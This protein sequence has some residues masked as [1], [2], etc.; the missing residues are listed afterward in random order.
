MGL[1]RALLLCLLLAAPATAAEPG[2]LRVGVQAPFVLDP[3][4]LFLGPN[5]AAARHIFDSLVGRDADSRWVPSLA[6][7]W[8]ALDETTWEFRLRRGVTFHDGSPFTAADVVATFGRVPAIPNNPS[9]YEPN[10]RTIV[11]TEVVDPWTIRLHTDRPNPTLPGQLTNIFVIPARLAKEPAEAASA[12]M[13][14]GTGPYKLVSFTYGQGME[15][16]RNDAYWGP[17]PAYA[18]V[19]IR[20]ITSDAAREAALLA[21]DI[22]LMENV[23]PEDVARLRAD[24]A[25]SVWSRAADRVVFLL[26]NTGADR[27]P[28]LTDHNGKPLPDNPLRDQRV[29]QAISLAIDRGALVSRV[30]SGQ[31]VATMQLVPE[32]FAGWTAS[33][34]V[35][36]PDPAAARALLAQAGFPEGLRLTLGCTNDRYIDDAR[37]CQAL[38]QM[39]ARAGIGTSVDAMPGSLF[40]A[41]TRL[42]KNDVPLIL[43]AISLSS[44]RDVAY[45]LAIAHTADDANGFV[46][47]RGGFS[48]PAL[49]RIIEAAI[50][51]SNPGRE[52]GLEEAQK[53]AVARLGLIPLY[54]EPTIAATRK[55]IVYVPRMDQQLVATGARPEAG[56][57]E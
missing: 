23:P 34:P 15:L 6:E 17:K 1:L 5:M 27:L 35:P 14:D 37:M 38:A 33:L 47:G 49:D 16:E 36:K 57:K 39:L 48:D 11:R 51:R 20:V 19:S 54:D 45:M 26:P 22:D 41:R 40:M 30:L 13:A 53:A 42:G 7:S 29:R 9:S 46:G 56:P 3:Q 44:L 52:A 8:T 43:Y 10:L 24:P 18:H 50:V 25:I 2:T 32:G 55:G 31:G 4:Y 21:G 28:L 12:R